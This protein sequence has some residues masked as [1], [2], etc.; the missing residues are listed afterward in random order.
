M[1]TRRLAGLRMDHRRSLAIPDLH[2]GEG[3]FDQER[4]GGGFGG[5][6]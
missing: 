6:R 5:G 3:S 2:V 4:S 1:C